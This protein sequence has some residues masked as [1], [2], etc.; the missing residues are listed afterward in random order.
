MCQKNIKRHQNRLTEP[1]VNDA[2]GEIDAV[3]CQPEEVIVNN[4]VLSFALEKQLK[5]SLLN[6]LETTIK[7][8]MN[9]N[10]VVFKADE[11][12]VAAMNI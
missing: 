3:C 8:R 6:K 10:E 7:S 4:T 1:I 5:L 11:S 2:S 9:G 12:H